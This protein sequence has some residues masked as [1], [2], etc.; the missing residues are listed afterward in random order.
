MLDSG[1]GAGATTAVVVAMD[2]EMGSPNT[3]AFM[4]ECMVAGSKKDAPHDRDSM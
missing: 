3:G 1:G 4:T 2:G